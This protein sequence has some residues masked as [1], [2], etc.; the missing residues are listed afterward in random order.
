[1]KTKVMIT[2]TQILTISLPFLAVN[3]TGGR[4][5]ALKEESIPM[6]NA[7]GVRLMDCIE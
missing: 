6:N 2:M 3:Y 1:M 7:S 4:L 5:H